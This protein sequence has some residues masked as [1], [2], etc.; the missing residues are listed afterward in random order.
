MEI[1]AGRPGDMAPRVLEDVARYRHKVFVETLGW[2]LVTEHGLERDQ[3]DRED[4]LYLAARDSAESIVGTARLLPTDRPYL[5]GDVFP[6]LLSG[7]PV[8]CDPR[9]WELSR[10]AAVDFT[11]TQGSAL[12]QFSSPVA[13]ALLEESLAIA[14]RNGV[15]RIITVSPLGVERLLRREGFRAHRAGPPMIVGGHPIFACWIEVTDRSA[16]G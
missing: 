16:L 13:V 2:D 15:E 5:L 9:I 1:L 12:G 7:M 6:Q 11:A 8:P 4:T 10:F 3:F 14:R